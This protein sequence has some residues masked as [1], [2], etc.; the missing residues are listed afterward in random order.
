MLGLPEMGA[1]GADSLAQRLANRYPGRRF[2]AADGS[3]AVLDGAA[4]TQIPGYPQA[5][6]WQFEY[7]ADP[8]PAGAL[9][10]PAPDWQPGVQESIGDAVQAA[11]GHGLERIP[12]GLYLGDGDGPAVTTAPQ[13]QPPP[14]PVQYQPADDE[15]RW[16]QGRPRLLAGGAG[17]TAGDAVD[18]LAAGHRLVMARFRTRRQELTVAGGEASRR[19]LVAYVG[20][21]NAYQQVY[22]A[23]VRP[24]LGLDDAGRGEVLDEPARQRL[25]FGVAAVESLL[26]LL[27]GGESGPFDQVSEGLEG[28]VNAA[29]DAV[30]ADATRRTALN[31][32]WRVYQEQVEV[33]AAVGDTDPAGLAEAATSWCTG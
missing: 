30:E 17:L 10:L 15:Q 12:A 18:M 26:W 28:W 6:W 21:V 23:L 25:V 32:A 2:L 3:L 13:P 14:Q 8:V 19:Q 1:G 22:E 16:Q 29:L 5:Q 9:Q 24:L 33:V 4:F 11:G 27:L 7:G 20:A 31:R